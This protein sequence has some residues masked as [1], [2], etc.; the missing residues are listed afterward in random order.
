M[1][2]LNL[3]AP[4]PAWGLSGPGAEGTRETFCFFTNPRVVGVENLS[5][6]QL[7]RDEPDRPAPPTET[8]DDRDRP[9]QRRP[10][11]PAVRPAR[12]RDGP[13]LA[14]P[15]A[16]QLFADFGAEVIKLE[17]PNQGD[18]LRVWGM[19]RT[20]GKALW[21][22][23]LGRN[24][25]SVTLQP[26]PRRG[27]ADRARHHRDRRRA[28][29][30]LPQRHARALGPL[31]RGAVGDQPRPGRS[32]ASP[33]SARPA[34]CH[35]AGYGAVGEAMGGLRYVMGDP[36]RMPSR[37]GISIGDTLAATF[38]TVGALMALH[39]RQRTGKGQLVDSALYEAV[40]AVMESLVIDYDQAG[41][42]RERTGSILP[43]IAPCNVYPTT[44]GEMLIAGNGDAI[45]RRMA[46]G[47]GMPE[48]GDDPRFADH[49]ARG[50]NQAE[51]DD[52]ITAWTKT[53]TNDEVDAA[54]D[55][56]EGA[57][58]Q[59]LHRAPRCSRTR[60]SR[61]AS[62]SSRSCTRS[63]A[64]S[65]CRTRSRS[66]RTPRARSA[67]S[68]RRSASTPTRSSKTCS[69]RP[70]TTSPSCARSAWSDPMP[71]AHP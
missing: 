63:S 57:A 65:R 15:F 27:P 39:A 29:R 11:R 3:F 69:A 6:A 58:R 46:A 64:R 43:K 53:K 26:A 67:G 12:R 10:P 22:S 17:P 34:R 28:H 56:G 60:S 37:A 1:L 59:D 36:D 20:N 47:M 61:R 4:R 16:G 2:S 23:V 9:R 41:Y 68:A 71:D 32:C 62:R 50:E 42:V 49:T 33:A 54:H 48:L 19:E 45:W 31:A 66:S 13:L 52:I 5:A 40:L 30:E 38:G 18:P 7:D 55:R 24:K 35:E 21:W 70:P 25:K 14:G 44:D 51:L 8:T